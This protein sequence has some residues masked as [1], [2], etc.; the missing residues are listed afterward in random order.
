MKKM[1]SPN[2][3]PV[4]VMY[5]PFCRTK[6]V[7]MSEWEKDIKTMSELGFSC[8]HGFS[9]WWR[10]EKQKGVF[11]FSETDYLIEL[12]DKYGIIPIINVATQFTVGYYMPRWMQQEY[13][14]KGKINS[15]GHGNPFKKQFDEPCLDDPWYQ[16][17]AERY[18][19]ALA[20][21][22]AGDK[23]IGGWVIWGEPVMTFGNLPI[24]YCEHTVA[25]FKNW[26]REKYKDI[27]ALNEAW[28]SEGPADYVDFHQICPPI[29]AMS[30]QGC[31]ASWL[32][33][34][35]FMEQNFASHIRNADRIFKENGATQ[36]TVVEVMDYLVPDNKP[37]STNVWTFADVSD[38]IGVSNFR[39]PSKETEIIMNIAGS[40]ADLEDKSIFVIEACGGPRYPNYD[41][42]TP[43][44][45]EICAEAVQMLGANAK[46]LMYWTY[47]PRLSDFESATYGMCRQD[48]KPLK[49]A[50]KAAQLAKDYGKLDDLFKG[51]RKSN[52]AVFHSHDIN[53]LTLAD[54]TVEIHNKTVRGAFEILCDLHISVSAINEKYIKDGALSKFDVLIMPHT[55]LLCEE[56]A[57]EV[58]KFVKNGGILI[59]D[60]Y[61]GFK[62][63]IGRAFLSQPGAGFDKV[64][65]FEREDVV[66]M[67]HIS[68]VPKSEFDIKTETAIDIVTPITAKVLYEGN[69]VPLV[70][71]NEYGKG[72]AIYFAWQMFYD[73]AENGI[74]NKGTQVLSEILKE[75]KAEPHL[76]VE[77]EKEN[78][79]PKLCSS[80][81]YTQ[82]GYRIITIVNPSYEEREEK[83]FIPEALSA[84][85]IYGT[86]PETMAEDGDNL[87]VKI[88]LGSFGTTVIKVK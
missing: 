51:T 1:I 45:E 79:L 23:R 38:V 27:E 42:R 9:E 21:H 16:M 69:G 20:K 5:A 34:Q 60:Q 64:L 25:R 35:N 15:T 87:C 72:K 30:R 17:Y 43:A 71:V 70:T 54:D 24:C 47:R 78:N 4:G 41:R 82:E 11:D 36:P 12:C 49:R 8:L 84:E 40:I 62:N 39:S 26:L 29:G 75:A 86:K 2:K 52:I 81:L 73:Y 18:L 80:V 3:I 66:Y 33:W 58:E 50:E 59:A 32:D 77:G 55:Y 6:A 67:D 46:G 63:R 7:D 57:K 83:V 88:K 37:F 61:F 53:R 22:Y 31:Y 14:G 19:K 44:D 10:V 48:G 85:C 68:R 13:T 74:S 65:G 76:W 28:G 56:V